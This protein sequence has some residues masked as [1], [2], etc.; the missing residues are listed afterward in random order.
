MIAL[1][2]LCGSSVASENGLRRLRMSSGHTREPG[3]GT[4]RQGSLDSPISVCGAAK[5][6]ASGGGPGASSRVVSAGTTAAKLF[7]GTS[8]ASCCNLLLTATLPPA[9]ASANNASMSAKACKSTMMSA[10]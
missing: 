1:S 6:P 2:S 9:N 5:D 10:S 8:W 4:D 3:D 7:V